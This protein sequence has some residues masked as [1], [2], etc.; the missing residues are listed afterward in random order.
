MNEIEKAAELKKLAEIVPILEFYG[1][2]PELLSRDVY[3]A[4]HQMYT[5]SLKPLAISETAKTQ[6]TWEVQKF[7]DEEAYK[8]GK[9]YET[10]VTTKNT[11]LDVGANQMLKIFG[12]ISG[13]TPYNNANARIGVGTSNEPENV[14]QT[15]LIATGANVFYKKMEAG[16]P[17]VTGRNIIFKST[18]DNTEANFAWNEFSIVNGT[19]VGGVAFNRK[20]QSLGTKTTG[21]WSLQ[22]TISVTSNS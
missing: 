16:Y 1:E 17:Q 8:A 21:I 13:A 6:I 11:V 7:K 12:G 3:D 20:V 15:G 19:G 22:V 18:F 5:L 4:I 14:S 2:H 9:P 10:R